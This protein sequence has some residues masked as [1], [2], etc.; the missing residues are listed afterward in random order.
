MCLYSQILR[1]KRYTATKKNG[2]DIP[3]VKDKRALWVPVGCGECMECRA[4]KKREWQCRLTEEVKTNRRLGLKGMWVTLTFSEEGLYKLGQEIE[5]L[6][7]YELENAIATLGMKRFRENWRK[8]RGKAPR[9]W[10]I[11]ELGHKNTER[12]HMHG[13]IWANPKEI[14]NIGEEVKKHWHHGNVWTGKQTSRGIVNYV[15]E[16]TINYNV[17]YV[18]KV[19]EQHKYYKPIVLCSPGIGVGYT[20]STK[21][22]DNIF[23]GEKTKDYYTTESGKKVKLPTYWRNKIFTED[24]KEEMWM[25]MLDKKTRYV[26]GIEIDISEGEENYYKTLKYY[27]SKNKRIGYG[28]GEINWEKKN[29]E[30]QRRQAMLDERWN[31]IKPNEEIKTKKGQST[32]SGLPR[33]AQVGAVVNLLGKKELEVKQ[34]TVGHETQNSAEI[35]WWELGKNKWE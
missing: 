31:K 10:F 26:A 21:A 19:D 16:K 12:I 18:H 8:H 20:T 22:K 27:Q 34:K 17:K 35:N 2:G 7:G 4:K 13:F 25:M 1:N 29:Y 33:F 14:E 6:T 15:T 3:P 30:N 23:I 9:R 28:S 11:T 32:K 5:G 24:Q